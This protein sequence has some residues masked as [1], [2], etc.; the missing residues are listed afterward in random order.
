MNEPTPASREALVQI[1]AL[2]YSD[3]PLI[4]C[5][6]D[7]VVLH[8]IRHLETYLADHGLSFIEHKYRLTG[9]IAE[10]GTQTPVSE[11]TVKHHLHAFFDS[12]SGHQDLVDGADQA[13]KD[14]S[15][16]WDIVFLTNLPGVHNKPVRER[17]LGG[18]GLPFPVVTNTGAKGGAASALS[19]GRR[20]PVAFIDDSPGNL[21]SVRTSL[22]TAHL[23]HFVADDRFLANSEDVPGVSLKTGD[24]R[25][26]AAHLG[27]IL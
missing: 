16:E 2:A 9:N 26:T 4:I 27:S 11:A 21:K 14:L 17:V 1:E 15:G 12:H 8:M 22:P 18:F 25:Q 13:L 3:A 5:D 6:V 19:A 20:G 7:E 10:H 24:W 23:V